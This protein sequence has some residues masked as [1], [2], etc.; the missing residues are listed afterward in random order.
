MVNMLQEKYNSRWSGETKYKIICEYNVI[1]GN[2][3][4]KLENLKIIFKT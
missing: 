3:F 1:L 4:H 2:T